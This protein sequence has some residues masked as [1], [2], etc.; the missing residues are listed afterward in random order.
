MRW[1]L[2][3]VNPSWR[4]AS[5]AVRAFGAGPVKGRIRSTSVELYFQKDGSVV[6]EPSQLIDQPGKKLA[7]RIHDQAPPLRQT[8]PCGR[9]KDRY[10]D[11][12]E[13][14]RE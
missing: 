4:E 5:V 3:G 2:A 8:P 9:A 7:L 14:I 11:W 1:Q 13:V 10:A 12:V 6:A